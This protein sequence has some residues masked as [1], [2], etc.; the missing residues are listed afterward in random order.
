MK[1]DN[2][3]FGVIGL[4]VGLIVG[5]IATNWMNRS[6]LSAVPVPATAGALDANAN[7][8]QLP[9]NHPPIGSNG[10]DAGAAGAGGAAQ[11]AQV[12]AAID[13]AKQNP[14]DY[15]AQ[16]TAAD[17]YYQIRRFDDAATYY[18]AAAKIKPNE[19]EPL[20]KLGDSYF[21]AA[22]TA[23][24]NNDQATANTKFPI[25]E[26][27]YAQVLAKDPKDLNVR[28]DLGLTY[29]LREPK[30]IDKAIENYK[31]SLAIDPKHEITLQNLAIAYKEKKDTANYQK[32]LDLLKSVNPNNPIFA[33]PSGGVQP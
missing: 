16:M 7:T 6:A 31:A 32:T 25:A 30:D 28:T 17:L 24:E 1:K 29:F 22:E 8:S 26:K 3:M 5:F 9:P 18:E 4:L 27:W 15:E 20:V 13:K 19:K 2:V 10:G 14:Q 23:S 12:Q 11:I 21:D 33:Q